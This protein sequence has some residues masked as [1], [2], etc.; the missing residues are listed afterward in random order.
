MIWKRGLAKGENSVYE[1]FS[2]IRLYITEVTGNVCVLG[3][4]LN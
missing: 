2:K 1:K 3:L 4:E